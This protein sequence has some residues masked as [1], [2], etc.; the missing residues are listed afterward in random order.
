MV[1]SPT[2][3]QAISN[4]K[5]ILIQWPESFISIKQFWKVTPDPKLPVGSLEASVV[6][7]HNFPHLCVCIPWAHPK[8]PHANLSLKKAQKLKPYGLLRAELG[9][10]TDLS[11]PSLVLFIYTVV[12]FSSSK[13]R[14]PCSQDVNKL[15]W[16]MN[17]TGGW[18]TEPHLMPQVEGKVSM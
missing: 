18:G 11:L 17:M 13:S 16:L 3:E 14:C 9:L 7:H 2:Q 5:W 8:T 6:L 12:H 10:H 1:A 4:D 15:T